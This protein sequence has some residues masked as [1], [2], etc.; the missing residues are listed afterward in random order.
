MDEPAHGTGL[1]LIWEKLQWPRLKVSNFEQTSAVLVCCLIVTGGLRCS[2]L[3]QRH[4]AL[5]GLVALCI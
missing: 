4:Q 2:G 3:I 5:L 1:L